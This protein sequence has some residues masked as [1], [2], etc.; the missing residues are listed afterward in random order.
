MFFKDISIRLWQPFFMSQALSSFMILTFI[1]FP[2]PSLSEF[3]SMSVA[4]TNSYIFTSRETH[5]QNL[6]ETALEDSSSEFKKLSED[7]QAFYNQVEKTI[8]EH[9]V[10]QEASHFSTVRLTDEELKKAFDRLS[11]AVFQ[12]PAWKSLEPSEK[13]WKEIFFRKV[14]ASKF[15][16]FRAQSSVIPVSDVE[17]RKYFNEN[18]LKF[19][20]SSFEQFQENIKIYLRRSQVEQR[21]KDWYDVL[22]SKHKARNLLSEI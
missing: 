5:I 21:L 20:D 7:S 2:K 3:L 11:K 4:R 1:L 16:Q 9:L 17:A 15:I 6:L 18:R 8:V 12:S 14:Q 13:E 22:R 10:A 19:G